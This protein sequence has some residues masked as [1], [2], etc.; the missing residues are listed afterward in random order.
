MNGEKLVLK[1]FV[2]SEVPS[3]R[4][5]LLTDVVQNVR[6]TIYCDWF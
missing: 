3:E 4:H 5:V 6:R 1:Y 2:K